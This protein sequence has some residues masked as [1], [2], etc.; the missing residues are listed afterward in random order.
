[1]ISA[2]DG[3]WL[4]RIAE[5]ADGRSCARVSIVAVRG[6]TPREIGAALLVTTDSCEG[7][8]GRGE[9]EQR[10]IAAARLAIAATP[11]GARPRWY[12]ELV[13]VD[14]GPVLGESSGGHVTLL[15]E[16]FGPA[17]I[18]AL[19]DRSPRPTLVA[20]PLAGNAPM[21]AFSDDEPVTVLPPDVAAAVERLQREPSRPRALVD[22]LDAQAP[23]WLVERITPRHRQFHVYGTGLIGRALVQALAGLPFE[24][25]WIDVEPAHFP[26][27]IPDGVRTIVTTDPAAVALAAHPGSFHAVMTVSHDRDHAVV[28]AL[29]QANVFAFAGVIGSRMK[30]KRLLS[31][32]AADGVAEAAVA[33]LVCP[34]GLPE[35]K[36]KSPPVIAISI[37]AQ[38]L[39]AL[40]SASATGD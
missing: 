3:D 14:T 4:S 16:T 22:S 15:V 24:V 5:L 36:T 27:E 40:Q 37:A 13:E 8:I 19:A 1:M 2:P 35:I 17:E 12:R 28:H 6:P 11:S 39:I 10:A 26:T 32:L 29:L 21:L 33:R 25:V 34:I 18:A 30:R 23:R 9:I 38:A 7:K 31:R 20:R